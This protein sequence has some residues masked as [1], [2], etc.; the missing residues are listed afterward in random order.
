MFNK[1]LLSFLC[2]GVYLTYAQQNTDSSKT[3]K[4][5]GWK[6]VASWKSISAF[7]VAV[8][9]DGNWVAYPLL[10]READGELLVQHTR[11][12]T[13]RKYN[14]GY[15]S[16]ADYRFSEDGKW[17]AFREFASFSDQKAA[18]KNPGK[19]L[20]TKLH[21]IELQTGKKTSIEKAGSFS[22]NG[23]NVSHMAVSVAKDRNNKATGSDLLLM[24]LT[25]GKIQNIGNTGDYGFNKN[26]GLLVYAIDAADKTGNGLYLLDIIAQKTTVLDNDTVTYKSINWS[27]EGNAF[28]ALKLKKDE[29]FKSD[30]GAVIAV[31]L[32]QNIPQVLQYQPLEDSLRFPKGY[33]ISANRP[34]YWSDDRA[35]IF[36][37]IAKLEPVEKAAA[38]SSKKDASPAVALTDS[39][40]LEKIKTDTAIKSV[41]DLKKA[42]EKLEDVKKAAPSPKK[43]EADKPDMAIW[44]W[45]DPRLQ[46]LQQK[47]EEQDKN[48]S[49]LAV[50]NISAKQFVQLND[51]TA[52]TITVLPKHK[53]ALARDIREYELDI[54]LDGKNYQ[55]VFVIN[56]ATGE[57]TSFAKK[58]YIPSYTSQ[59]QPA[60]DG[61]KFV[62]GRD[63]H[64]YVRDI[65][66]GTDVN[67][68]QNIPVS[69]IDTEDDHNVEK[70]LTDVLG[71]SSD[72]KYILLQDGWDIWQV[73]A[74][75]KTFVNLTQNGRRD[76]I[77]Y[78]N[79][80]IIDSEEKGF[81][82]KKPV[83]VHTYGERS[84]KSGIVRIDA[85]KNGLKPGVQSLIWDDVLI[86]SFNKAKNSNVFVYAKEKFNQPTNFY[87]T[88]EKFATSKQ[89]T[90]NAPDLEKYSWSNGVQLVDYI[91]D[92][93]D[94]LQGALFLP[95]GYVKGKK[96]PTVVYYYEKMSQSLH[97]YSVPDY[98]RAAWNPNVYTSNGY[99]VF[100]PDI[101]YTLDDPGMSAVWCV[102][103]GVKAAVQ[104]GVIDEKNI[105]IHG[106]SWG[107][108]QT[109]FLA[110]QTNMFKAAAAGA[111]L[112]NLVSMYDL[113]YWNWGNSNMSIFESSQGRFR[114]GPW[115]NWDAYLRNSPLYHV[116]KVT[117]PLL[118]LHNDKDGAVDFTQGIE[119]YNAL[120]RLKKPVVMLQ[121]KGENHGL[122]KMENMKDYAVRMMEF[123]DHHLKGKPA[124]AWLKDGVKQLKL[125]EHLEERAF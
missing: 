116:K 37:G 3:A 29:K 11:D 124:P 56:T 2:M 106:H 57:R 15:T 40:K 100:M 65:V 87:V 97:Q 89:V 42:L 112:T 23:K 67:I 88:D 79:R 51:S 58:M 10:A 92:K 7:N 24:H 94:S 30:K 107:G 104:T 78:Q 74:D 85:A 102:L 115:E 118:L 36:F 38:D 45:S 77:R 75:G 121:Y 119:F 83:Y 39:Q 48:G 59:P 125:E 16:G 86:R 33:T 12:T 73:T 54:N 63:G 81:D 60:P 53:Y 20:Y 123:F 44:H 55:D 19:Q 108:Y 21:L 17:L 9:P 25:S 64:F 5:F 120:R 14:I 49:Y 71:W 32:A 72:N 68:T 50:Y 8:S 70:P 31:T 52:E 47:Q 98:P 1:I 6:D 90:K 114:G 110:T 46:S 69:F 91:S 61:S 4:P 66:A 99:A 111:A 80:Y 93:G 62:Y 103:P 84:K 34:P 117:T 18:K 41:A 43:N 22:F 13:Q 113:I 27:D 82:A 101:V 76:K 105:G 26:G 95:A 35:R 122:A 28:A 96:Y 109:C